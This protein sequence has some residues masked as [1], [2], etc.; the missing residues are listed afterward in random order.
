[1]KR[2]L[3][4][5]CL[6][7]ALVSDAQPPAGTY[8]KVSNGY[9]WLRG[10]FQALHLPSGGTA[11]TLKPSQWNGAGAVYLD[12]VA[13]IVYYYQGGNW[14]AF[15]SGSG[16]LTQI[17]AGT[18]LI[19]VNDSTLAADTACLSTK[20]YVKHYADSIKGTIPIYTFPYSVVSPGNAVQLDND[21]TASPANYF[22]GRNSVGRRGWYPQSS[23]LGVVPT[24]Q[25]VL[26]A[27]SLL[28]GNNTINAQTN[29]LFFTGTNDF[30]E[31]RFRF[32]NTNGFIRL[33]GLNSSLPRDSAYLQILNEEGEVLI[34]SSNRDDN[35]LARIFVNP[36]FGAVME[37]G[38]S[39]TTSKAFSVTKDFIAY[40]GLNSSSNVDDSMLVIDA[41]SGH[42]GYRAIPT[43]S[44]STAL[45]SITAATGTNTIDNG[46]NDQVWQ[47]NTLSDNAGLTLYSNSTAAASSSQSLLTVLMEGANSN[48]GQRT[49]G[50]VVGNTHTGTTSTNVGLLAEASGGSTNYAAQFA[51][52][53]TSFGTAGT[54]SGVLEINGSTS[55]TVTIQP[56]AA[57]GTP[58]LTL[59]TTTSTLV[60][61]V[62]TQTLTNKRWVPRVGSTTSSATPTINT[63]NVDIY[64]LTAQAAD[65]TSFT[66]NLSGTP[67]DGEIL[68]IQI[69]G[70]AARAI[71]WGSSFVSSTV[72]LPTTT[73]TTATLT[74]ILQYYTTSSYG[75]NK[76]V[77]VNYY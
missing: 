30:G 24:L 63:D 70:T 9:N 49:T 13:N 43:G 21:T 26:T 28:T 56:A 54:E 39:T 65:I 17:F 51:R 73:V 16:N 66:T 31:S 36:S 45:S 15:G 55:G 6:L 22:Y 61:D 34:A 75:N 29:E 74:V 71:T 11:P 5:I 20:L 53:K 7:F 38:D 52:G 23:I 32:N 12:S 3:L 14:Q 77:C 59:P 10:Y 57:A 27:G 18:C 33:I 41:S 64:K 37:A 1:M 40:A 62:V 60:G 48:S 35:S 50:L 47:W 42:I 72:T 4:F 46:N 25:Q 69:T 68:E 76:W 67:N 19:A 2:I 44:G 8:T 58:T